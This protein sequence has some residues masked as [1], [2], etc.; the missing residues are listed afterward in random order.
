[1]AS[2]SRRHTRRLVHYGAS[3]TGSLTLHLLTLLDEPAPS[4]SPGTSR[5]RP[6]RLP[7]VTGV[8]RIGLPP[9]SSGRCDDPKEMVSH[10]PSTY[11]APRGA[12]L[13]GEKRRLQKS[14]WLLQFSVLTPQPDE[15]LGLRRHAR[16]VPSAP[17][18]STHAGSRDTHPPSGRSLARR[19]RQTGTHQGDPAPDAR[20]SPE[21][22]AGSAW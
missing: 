20:P 3:D 15:F 16:R 5:L 1:M 4:G 17:S 18:Q 10:H 8:L 21:P 12:Q 14:H 11:T 22:R 6:G 9:A 13:S 7:P 2:E 19:R